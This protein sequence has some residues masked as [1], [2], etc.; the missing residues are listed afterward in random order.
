MTSI[1][2]KRKKFE[3]P[4]KKNRT[5]I[6]FALATVVIVVI[7]IVAYNSAIP[8][9]TTKTAAK[10]S[11]QT[12]NPVTYTKTTQQTDVGNKVEANKLVLSLDD[13]KSKNFVRTFYNQNGKKLP[14]TAFLNTKGDLVAAVGVCEPCKG[15]SFRIEGNKI[16]CNVCG[17]TWDLDT[18][19]GISGGCTKYPP[20][21][22]K[23]TVEGN[24]ILIDEVLVSSWQPRV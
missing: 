2:N 16:I 1:A 23:Y 10:A 3:Q 12:G 7:G 8:P 21:T 5:P 6:I 14:I 18:L 20:D 17:T 9:S 4:T 24:N 19:A 13:V 11:Y 15:E 22:L